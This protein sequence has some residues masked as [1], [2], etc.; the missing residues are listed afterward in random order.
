MCD[1]NQNIKNGGIIAF[2]SPKIQIPLSY[3]QV[4]SL[5]SVYG[6]SFLGI[7]LEINRPW[8]INMA[9][10]SSLQVAHKKRIGHSLNL[11]GCGSLKTSLN[12]V[13]I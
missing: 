5:V 8:Q 11:I 2:L 12:S 4:K 3:L 13:M 7:V 10:K 1:G 6:P 9:C